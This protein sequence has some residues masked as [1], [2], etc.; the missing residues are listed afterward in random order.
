[1]G[2]NLTEISQ[3]VLDTVSNASNV[4][5]KMYDLHYNPNPIDV[6]MEYIDENGQKRTTQVPNV[7]KFRKRV[8]DDVGGALGQFNRT[9]YVDQQNG[10]DNNE[11]SNNSSLKSIQRAI[12][13]T[14]A[15]GVC[16]VYLLNDYL[17]S[18]TENIRIFGAKIVYIHLMGKT[19]STSYTI[20]QT[21]QTFS[22]RGNFTFENSSLYID[23]GS[24]TIILP[25]NPTGKPLDPGTYGFFS[26]AFGEEGFIH[27]KIGSDV[28]GN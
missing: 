19:L 27:F 4:F 12:D 28:G 5:R 23:V 24:G 18:P 2:I 22:H 6:P 7:A 3:K 14:P 10:D 17:L 25:E 11:G 16:Q 8:W 20:N 15:G 13:L 21:N 1:M 26:V 9:F